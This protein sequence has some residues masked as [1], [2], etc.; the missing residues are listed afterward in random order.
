MWF[1][2]RT[3]GAPEGREG[4]HWQ[5]SLEAVLFKGEHTHY[6]HACKSN[7]GCMK[8]EVP[9]KILTLI[10]LVRRKTKNL[11][12][13]TLTGN[14]TVSK[15][16]KDRR[17]FNGCTSVCASSFPWQKRWL[18]HG[19]RNM[20]KRTLLNFCPLPH[21]SYLSHLKYVQWNQQV[22]LRFTV[23]LLILKVSIKRNLWKVPE[24]KM[25]RL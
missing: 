17:W 5:S 25:G 13:L 23:F 10:L 15:S 11:K 3:S 4:P 21:S 14:G 9:F 8:L 12:S 7:P 16:D 19:K 20:R 22:Y 6:F 18:C 1:G 2:R 24:K